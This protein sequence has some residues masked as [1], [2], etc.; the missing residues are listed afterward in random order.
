MVLIFFQKFYCYEIVLLAYFYFLK[1][2]AYN[3]YAYKIRQ[4]FFFFANAKSHLIDTTCLGFLFLCQWS[5][6]AP[7]ERVWSCRN[8]T[9]LR[10]IGHLC[11]LTVALRLNYS[12]LALSLYTCDGMTRVIITVLLCISWVIDWEESGCTASI[13]QTIRSCLA[14]LPLF[15]ILKISSTLVLLLLSSL[16][17]HL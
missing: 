9:E 8:Y 15:H 6:F 16:C 13:W 7:F 17:T 2:R 3:V 5:L 11:S 12:D 1:E 14:C 4:H 10:C